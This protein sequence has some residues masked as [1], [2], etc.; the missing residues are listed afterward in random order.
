MP[1]LPPVTKTPAPLIAVMTTS[2]KVKTD[3]FDHCKP[4]GFI[5]Q[6][7][8]HHSTSTEAIAKRV[9]V[10]R[11]YLF[12]L[13]P[14]KRRSSSPPRYGARKAPARLSSGRSAGWEQ[15]AGP[16]RHAGRVRAAD[17][18]ALRT[19][20]DADAGILRRRGHRGRGR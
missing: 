3:R 1:R 19:L 6:V 8:G 14:G 20:P 10:T 15:R 13:F 7:E 4:I 17:L 12:R 18:G 9:G 11:P 16:G 5:M 2:T